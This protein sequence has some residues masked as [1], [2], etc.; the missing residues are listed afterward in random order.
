MARATRQTTKVTAFVERLDAMDTRT[1]IRTRAAIVVAWSTVIL[2]LVLALNAFIGYLT[3]WSF[4]VP[5][6]EGPIVESKIHV[7]IILV[8]VYS[9]LYLIAWCIVFPIHVGKMITGV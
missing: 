1:I 6:G 8:Y 3:D 7:G 9:F 2:L 5:S 4:F